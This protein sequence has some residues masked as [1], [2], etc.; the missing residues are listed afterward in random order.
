MSFAKDLI[1]DREIVWRPNTTY[2]RDVPRYRRYYHANQE[3]QK[4][5]YTSD[6]LKM[7]FGLVIDPKKEWQIVENEE[8]F[9]EDKVR[10]EFDA[11]ERFPDF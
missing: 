10:A 6:N 2:N 5:K 8:I 3:H 11:D 9:S 1:K 7:K 4:F